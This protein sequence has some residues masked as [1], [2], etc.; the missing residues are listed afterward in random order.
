V[1]IVRCLSE[2]GSASDIVANKNT[3]PTASVKSGS[4]SEITTLAPDAI[5]LHLP[6]TVM[7]LR[8]SVQHGRFTLPRWQLSGVL[9]GD[10]VTL[11]GQQ[12]RVVRDT[13]DGPVHAWSGFKI[14][15]YK[16]ASDYDEATAYLETDQPVLST[17]ITPELYRHMEGFV[18]QQYRPK[19]FNKRKRK[20]W[21]AEA[22]HGKFG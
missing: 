10:H 6:V 9:Y 19:P 21:Q 7:L 1:G 11:E 17:A 12:G 8:G 3:T 18:L 2:V 13:S 14:T 5:R 4:S 15:L 22:D 20:N 16:D